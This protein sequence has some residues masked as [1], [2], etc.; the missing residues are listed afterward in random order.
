MCKLI[1]KYLESFNQLVKLEILDSK[2]IQFLVL[3]L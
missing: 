3:K 2:C 1:T